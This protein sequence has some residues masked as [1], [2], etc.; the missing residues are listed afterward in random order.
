MSALPSAG[1]G[2]CVTW[3]QPVQGREV[4]GQDGGA[5][6]LQEARDGRVPCQ[7]AMA[8]PELA[9]PEHPAGRP[10]QPPARPSSLLLTV[11]LH[12]R[13][14]PFGLIYRL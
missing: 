5:P 9:E 14:S 13:S 3:E 12:F 11:F 6:L 1:K 8:E 4:A 2:V 7:V 10:L